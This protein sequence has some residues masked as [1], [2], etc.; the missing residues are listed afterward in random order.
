MGYFLMLAISV[1]DIRCC[2]SF[3]L[4]DQDSV[5]SCPSLVSFTKNKMV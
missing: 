5:G 2:T 4:Q 3:S 1:L